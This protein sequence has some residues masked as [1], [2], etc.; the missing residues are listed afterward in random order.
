MLGKIVA[1]YKQDDDGEDRLKQTASQL[2][3]MVEKRHL[4]IVKVVVSQ[5]LSAPL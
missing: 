1:D 2:N 3:Q 4:G 5:G